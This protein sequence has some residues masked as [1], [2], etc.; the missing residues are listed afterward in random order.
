MSEE[1]KKQRLKNIKNEYDK[2]KSALLSTSPFIASIL[3]RVKIVLTTEVPTAG[4]DE[5]DIMVINPDWWEE[6]SMKDRAWVLAHEVMHLAFR[7]LER[8]KYRDPKGWNIIAD[9]INN[10]IQK[11]MFQM[12]DYMEEH[13]V[14]LDKIYREFNDHFRRLN[15]NNHDLNTLS[16]EE[17]YKKIPWKQI[18]IPEGMGGGDLRY[19]N[20]DNQEGDGQSEGGNE[21]NKTGSGSRKPDIDGEM[22]Q[23]GYQNVYDSDDDD[24]ERIWR[25]V[26]AEAWQAQKTIGTMPGNLKRI[27]DGILTPKV[28]WQSRLRQAM[29]T[30]MGKTVVSSYR[31]PSRKHYLF[32]GINRFTIPTV[33]PLI[34]T[35]GSIGGQEI[36]V[37]MTEIYSIAKTSPVSALCW[38]TE[39]YGPVEAKSQS[40]VITKVQQNIKGG[41]GTAIGK[42]IYR[43][44]QLM[45]PRDIV[46]VFTDGYISDIDE[47][48]IRRTMY[49]VASKASATIFCT[50]GQKHD[51][52]KWETID[53]DINTEDPL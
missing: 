1:E 33:W 47:G 39:V 27:I 46:I 26:L 36:K 45:K 22:L 13:G 35:S 8:R 24:K 21:D 44:R 38:D 23:D 29:I 14:T 37:V 43:V 3:R 50:T 42:A 51:I 19:P 28:D 5:R 4:V 9:G 49:E 53:I 11:E 40:E 48:N 17:L 34:D 30:G 52:E 10:E 31:R 15:I 6:I 41:G 2:L 32:P 7:D 18:R 25:E 16:K 12:P 20:R